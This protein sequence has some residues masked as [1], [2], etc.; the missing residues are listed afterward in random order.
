[1]LIVDMLFIRKDAVFMSKKRRAAIEKDGAATNRKLDEARDLIREINDDKALPENAEAK[2][3]NRSSDN[4]DDL[5]DDNYSDDESDEKNEN[6]ESDEK[7]ETK[8]GD[9]NK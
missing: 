6:D 9:E 2:S 3:A 8:S 5:I 1:M 7:N 4:Y